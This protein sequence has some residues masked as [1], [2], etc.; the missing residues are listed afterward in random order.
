MGDPAP[1]I[2]TTHDE[3]AVSFTEAEAQGKVR[4]FLSSADERE[5]RRLFRLCSQDQWNYEIAKAELPKIDLEAASTQLSY[6]PFDTRWTIWNS[7]VA[8]HRRERVMRHMLAENIAITTSR[9]AGVI[10]SL[11]FDAVMAVDRPVDFNFYRRGGEYVFPAYLIPTIS[12]MPRRENLATDFRNFLDARYEHHYTPEEVLGYIYAVLHAPLYRG[13]YAEFLRTDFPRVPF[14]AGANDFEALSSLGWA[15]VQAHVLREL[16]R[17]GLAAYHGKGDHIVEIVRYSSEDQTIAIN[18]T[19]FFKPVPQ[20]VWKYH[21]GGY[22]VLEKY[23]KSR[24]GRTLSLDEI[25]HV[26]SIAD[27]IAF[28]IEQMTKIDETYGLAFAER[29]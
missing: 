8:V 26:G 4:A 17:R 7:N 21:I 6:R 11:D 13:R 25:N 14:P 16:Q 29:G 19:Q 9:Q 10:G 5:A 23:L 22:Q 27:S 24:K 1:G 15:L 2:V 12:G 18:K 3:F 20:A 28:T